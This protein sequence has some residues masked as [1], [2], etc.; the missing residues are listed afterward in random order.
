M[1][2]NPTGW[3]DFLLPELRSKRY[4][5]LKVLWWAFGW[6]QDELVFSLTA[7]ILFCSCEENCVSE[8]AVSFERSNSSEQEPGTLA[9]SLL[10]RYPPA[11]SS[12]CLVSQKEKL[13]PVPDFCWQICVYFCTR[14]WHWGT[15]FC[16]LRT[17]I[18]W[19]TSGHC[20][21]DENLQSQLQQE[22]PLGIYSSLFFNPHPR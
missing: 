3:R 4:L 8:R 7:Y 19:C 10:Q 13:V 21:R 12:P 9:E 1:W 6:C 16:S 20:Y 11:C 17:K 22:K 18:L 5:Q 14:P 15:L 2:S